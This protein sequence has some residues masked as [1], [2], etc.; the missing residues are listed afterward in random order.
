MK[1]FVFSVGAAAL[2]SVYFLNGM[3]FAKIEPVTIQRTSEAK[4]LKWREAVQI[5]LRFNPDLKEAHFNVKSSARSRD[6]A[7]GDSVLG[8]ITLPIKSSATVTLPT[9]VITL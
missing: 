5:A 4:V 1:K 9:T 7:F 2:L 8:S 3:S 6:I